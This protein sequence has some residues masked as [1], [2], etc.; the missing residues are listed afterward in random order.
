MPYNP[1][2]NVGVPQQTPYSNYYMQQPI[3]PVQPIQ[4]LRQQ[5]EPYKTTIGNLQGKS[6]DSVDVVK[7]MDIPYDGSIS[8]FPLTDNSAIITKQL[9]QDGTSKILIYKPVQENEEKKIEY[10]TKNDINDALKDFN[11]KEVKDIKD[12][13]KTL[14]KQLRDL[15][16][17]IK[18]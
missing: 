4:P 5:T 9:Q 1:Y 8:Y 7:A 17:D 16:D 11:N 14:K 6:V 2:Y 12:D 18:E 13:L 3:Q 10:A 15:A